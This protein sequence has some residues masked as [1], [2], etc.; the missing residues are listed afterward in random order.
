VRSHDAEL[1]GEARGD[2]VSRGPRHAPREAAQGGGEQVV[3]VAL[4]AGALD[5]GSGD[6][7]GWEERTEGRGEEEGEAFEAAPHTGGGVAVECERDAAREKSSGD[8]TPDRAGVEVRAAVAVGRD[9]AEQIEQG[10]GLVG[11]GDDVERPEPAGLERSHRAG[12][13]GGF[14][15]ARHGGLHEGVLAGL[16]DGESPRLAERLELGGGEELGAEQPGVRDLAEVDGHRRRPTVGARRA[17]QPHVAG[18]AFRQAAAGP[19]ASRASSPRG[20]AR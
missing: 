18:R 9:G 16:G 20:R 14:E 2:L 19:W 3:D 15:E 10:D 8:L 6:G 13:A 1:R 12:D 11:C 5:G 7:E 17:G 4:N